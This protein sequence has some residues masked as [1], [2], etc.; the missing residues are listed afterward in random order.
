MPS[1]GVFS[2][3]AFERQKLLTKVDAVLPCHIGHLDVAADAVQA[4]AWSAHG[5]NGWR[6]FQIGLDVDIWFTPMPNHELSPE[7]REFDLA[8]N[9]V[10]KDRRDV[11]PDVWTH[12]RTEVVRAA[13]QDP[14]VTRIFVNPA[15]KKVMC[16]EAGSDRSWLAKV[17]PWWGTTS[18]FTSESLVHPTAR[19]ASRNRRPRRLTDAATSSIP[20]SRKPCC[21]RRRPAQSQSTISHSQRCQRSAERS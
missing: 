21:I 12:E 1:D 18:I 14:A 6:R 19:N 20:G 4:V 13:A 7:Q 15:I 17:R 11:D 5:C 3:A 16:R 10:A 2:S 9:M 8:L